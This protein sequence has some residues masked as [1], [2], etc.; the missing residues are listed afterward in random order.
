MITNSS[1]STLGKLSSDDQ[2]Y[3]NLRLSLNQI[4]TF[5]GDIQQ[6]KGT[7]GRLANDEQL[8]QNLNEVSAEVIKLI[9]DFRQNPKEFLTIKLEIF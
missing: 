9:Y 8:Y 7:L 1:S 4:K 5:F 3:E 6:G 2:L